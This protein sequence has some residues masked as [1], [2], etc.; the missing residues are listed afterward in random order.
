MARQDTIPRSDTSRVPLP[1]RI[2]HQTHSSIDQRFEAKSEIGGKVEE[3][4]FASQGQWKRV[5]FVV[6]FAVSLGETNRDTRRRTI[7]LR[8]LNSSGVAKRS[9]ELIPA[10]SALATRPPLGIGSHSVL[11]DLLRSSRRI[12]SSETTPSPRHHSL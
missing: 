8:H 10:A 4:K 2:A 7:C 6:S 12:A 1:T 9:R 5:V 3:S 11:A